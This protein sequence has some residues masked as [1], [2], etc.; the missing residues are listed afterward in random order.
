MSAAAATA[1]SICHGGK[2]RGRK[3]HAETRPVSTWNTNDP[4]YG[5]W[6]PLPVKPFLALLENGRLPGGLTQL[7]MLIDIWVRQN[8]RPPGEPIRDWAEPIT[9]KKWQKRLGIKNERQFYRLKD[10]SE[11]QGFMEIARRPGVPGSCHRV[12]FENWLK[13]GTDMPMPGIS[14]TES[15]WS[16]VKRFWSQYSRSQNCAIRTPPIGSSSRLDLRAKS[17]LTWLDA[18]RAPGILI[19]YPWKPNPME[20]PPMGVVIMRMAG[21]DNRTNSRSRLRSFLL[22]IS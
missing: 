18:G 6:M 20:D 7:R 10:D 15:F 2:R 19:R 16:L 8:A 12:V 1:A 3:I 17:S 22:H 21:N 9:N 5:P 13:P 14:A 11:N 4:S